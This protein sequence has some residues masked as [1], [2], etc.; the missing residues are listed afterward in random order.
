MT[1]STT[2]MVFIISLLSHQIRP[3]CC[4]ISLFMLLL[5]TPV[6]VLRAPHVRCHLLSPLEPSGLTECQIGENAMLLKSRPLTPDLPVYLRCI[7]LRSELTFSLWK[8]ETEKANT[9]RPWS[10][11]FSTTRPLCENRQTTRCNITLLRIIL[12]RFFFLSLSVEKC[13]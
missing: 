12:T 7:W 4:F 6:F 1:Q 9:S 2:W 5:R 10:F 3:P 13:P 11:L 8:P